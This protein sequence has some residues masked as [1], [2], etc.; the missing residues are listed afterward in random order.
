LAENP[1][2][3]ELSFR[4]IESSSVNDFEEK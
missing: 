2:R 3:S 4:L 1:Q